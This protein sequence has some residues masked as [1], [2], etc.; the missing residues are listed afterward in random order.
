M[1]LN[2]QDLFDG[3]VDD[4]QD[5]DALAR[6]DEVVEGGD[7]TNQLHCAEGEGRD[8]TSRGWIFKHQSTKTQ[9]EQILE[10]D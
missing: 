1:F 2:L 5:E 10:R 6:H 8:T 7:V 9:Q 4:E 3:V